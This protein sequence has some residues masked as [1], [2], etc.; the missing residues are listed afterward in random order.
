MIRHVDYINAYRLRNLVNKVC[1]G[2]WRDAYDFVALYRTY[3]LAIA[4][5]LTVYDQADFAGQNS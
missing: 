4:A 1:G 2:G 3:V 5:D